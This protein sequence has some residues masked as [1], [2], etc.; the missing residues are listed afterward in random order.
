MARSSP[1]PAAL[2]RA[3]ILDVLRA[4]PAWGKREIGRALKLDAAQKVELKQLLHALEHDGAI[5]RSGRKGYAVAGA[6]PKVG[7]VEF[8]D[9]DTDGDLVGRLTGREQDHAGPRIR[10]VEERRGGRRGGDATAPHRCCP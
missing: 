1:P 3:A 8:T 2:D 10:L 7:V 6:V 4:N 5:E 9:H